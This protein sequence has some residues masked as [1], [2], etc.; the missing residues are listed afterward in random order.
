MDPCDVLV[1]IVNYRSAAL[2]LRALASLETER[3][4]PELRLRAVV[5][6]NDSGDAEQLAQG[7]RERFSDFAELVISPVN[8]GFGAG[9]NLGIR[10]AVE[11]GY[12]FDYVQLLN[13]DTEA[14]PG[15]LTALARFLNEHPRAGLASGSFEHQ[16]GTPWT[17]AFRFPSAAGEFEAGAQLGLVS[18]LLKRRAVPRE[19]GSEPAQIDWCAGASLMLRR[20]VLEQVG[21]FDEAFFLYYEEVDLCRRIR[22]AGWECWYVPESRVMHVR[23]QST[24][25]T[26]LDQK[27]RRLP[28]YWFESRRRYFVKHHGAGYTA[29]ADLA[30]LLG[31]GLGTLKQRLR[32]QPGTPYLLRDLLAHSVLRPT[33][34]APLEAARCYVPTPAPARRSPRASPAIVA[35]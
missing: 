28:G 32:G 22:A 17:I 27:P 6:E 7:I 21:G 20:E 19:M 8:G 13:P 34:R 14:R 3:A 35:L 2:T 1:V 31:H 29:L 23:G 9:N 25:V 15:A 33:R 11:R 5:V 24:G 4:Q 26:A 16:D 18:R 10:T 12:A 30:S